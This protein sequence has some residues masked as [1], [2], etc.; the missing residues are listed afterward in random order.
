MGELCAAFEEKYG[1]AWSEDGRGALSNEDDKE[2]AGACARHIAEAFEE[3]GRL[4]ETGL[5]EDVAGRPFE[6]VRALG[7]SDGWEIWMQPGFLLRF[8][9]E[10]GGTFKAYPEEAY[11]LDEAIVALITSPGD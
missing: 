2:F 5:E 8:T 4:P 1:G 10:L 11:L 9:D 3:R 7:E 6:V